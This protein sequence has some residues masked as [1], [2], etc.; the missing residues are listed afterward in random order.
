M[1]AINCN[2][3]HTLKFVK[4][5]YLTTR[6]IYFVLLET[7]AH[8]KIMTSKHRCVC[9][10]RKCIGNGTTVGDVL[11]KKC[12]SFFSQCLCIGGFLSQKCRRKF[13]GLEKNVGGSVR[14]YRHVHI[15]F[16]KYY[17]RLEKNSQ[18]LKYPPT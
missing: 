10:S 9:L 7:G 13:L 5:L 16:R 6:I 11:Q 15:H 8:K 17:A 2:Y 3:T 4:I 12:S 1:E 14:V 18:N